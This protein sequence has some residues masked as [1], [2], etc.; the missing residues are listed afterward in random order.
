MRA[1]AE[2]VRRDTRL[3]VALL[4]DTVYV[5]VLAR[6]LKARR[7]EVEAGMARGVGLGGIH[8]VLPQQSP[9][10]QPLAHLRLGDRPPE[11][12]PLHGLG[13]SSAI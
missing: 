9:M 4:A 13:A 10:T 12:V 5:F 6:W 11:V 8:L 7:A 1:A 2:A 3:R